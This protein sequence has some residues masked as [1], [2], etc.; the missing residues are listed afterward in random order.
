MLRC[1]KRLRQRNPMPVLY[2]QR[3][4]SPGPY[5]TDGAKSKGWERMARKECGRRAR[6]T[7]DLGDANLAVVAL[8]FHAAELSGTYRFEF[9]GV[10]GQL[11][12]HCGA[13]LA[14]GAGLSLLS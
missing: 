7:M 14:S 6:E 3:P 12:A 11:G 1:Y 10:I 9:A 4:W 5:P 13:K 8:G 2:I